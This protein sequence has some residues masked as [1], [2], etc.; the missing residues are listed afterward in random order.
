MLCR[1]DCTNL[2]SCGT[3]FVIFPPY[4]FACCHPSPVSFNL[5]NTHRTHNKNS[6]LVDNFLLI[7]YYRKTCSASSKSLARTL[8][9]SLPPPPPPSSCPRK[10]FFHFSRAAFI[11]TSRDI[12]SIL[13][14]H[15]TQHSTDLLA[16][17]YQIASISATQT[18]RPSSIPPVSQSIAP[19][20]SHP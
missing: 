1:Y 8:S 12:H 11:H 6:Q 13:Y 20:A 14:S 16:R 7:F 10:H 17:V 19:L 4:F 15:T 5:V 9:L 3:R 2:L 18:H